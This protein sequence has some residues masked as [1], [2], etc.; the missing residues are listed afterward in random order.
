MEWVANIY[1]HKKYLCSVKT[2]ADTFLQAKNNLRYRFF[3]T[4]EWNTIYKKGFYVKIYSNIKTPKNIIEDDEAKK[5]LFKD[6]AVCNLQ[7]LIRE[8]NSYCYEMCLSSES[9]RRSEE[10]AE[11]LN[12][13]YAE[14]ISED[15]PDNEDVEDELSAIAGI[16]IDNRYWIY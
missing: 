5:L 14:N 11:A 7:Q 9:Y 15:V 8:Y 4:M 12:K 6:E 13:W 2:Q 3:D 16:V 1:R 10:Y